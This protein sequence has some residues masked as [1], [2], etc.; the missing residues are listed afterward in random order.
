MYTFESR[1]RYSETGP[2]GRLRLEAMLNYLQDCSTFQSED[3]GIGIS[4]MKAEHFAWIVN[5]WQ[6][7]ILELPVLGDHIVIGTSPYEL[8][9]FIG[10][11][12]FCIGRD[13]GERLINANSVWSLMDLEHLRPVRVP[14]VMHEK[15]TLNPRFDM[16]YTSRKIMIPK[17]GGRELEKI[18][19]TESMIDSN[20]HVN[21]A[22]YVG[23]ALSCAAEYDGA[24][25]DGIGRL[26]AEYRRQ[27]HLG[28]VITPVCYEE[29]GKT[30]VLNA[31]DGQPYCVVHLLPAAKAP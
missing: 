26:R 16:E 28:D 14:E 2:D 7:D 8:K 18:T 4:Y 6:I 31:D 24:G 27:A 15:Y 19:V 3:L 13:N 12:N 21:N 22:R 1:I 20:N 29:D 25:E 5:Y 10:L 30:I 9:G 11:R 17:E 23:I